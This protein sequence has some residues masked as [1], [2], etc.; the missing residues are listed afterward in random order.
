MRCMS[1]SVIQ[2]DMPVRGCWEDRHT[3]TSAVNGRAKLLRP[4]S[5]RQNHCL[6][7]LNV[8]LAP[9]NAAPPVRGFFSRAGVP[10][11]DILACTE[12][13]CR[14]V[15]GFLW[16]TLPTLNVEIALHECRSCTM[17]VFFSERRALPSNIN[18]IIR[19]PDR[20]SDALGRTAFH[21]RPL[22]GF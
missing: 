20:P 10:L 3:T 16:T 6:S 12:H 15:H 14:V 18:A 11:A 17:L 22:S 13:P 4:P 1:R 9:S 7:L 5:P 2:P 21:K 8:E 19:F